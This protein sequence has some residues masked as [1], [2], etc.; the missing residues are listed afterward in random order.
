MKFA[1]RAIQQRGELKS[2][3]SEHELRV[4]PSVQEACQLVQEAIHKRLETTCP[5]YAG[6]SDEALLE[7]EPRP[8]QA[9]GTIDFDV[10]V[11]HLLALC[12]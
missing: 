1:A 7:F 11:Q 4:K 6:A 9:T 12:C 10:E 2:Q 3:N 8:A 5:A